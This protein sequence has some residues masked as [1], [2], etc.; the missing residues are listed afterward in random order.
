MVG[1]WHGT[2][3]TCKVKAAFSLH[4]PKVVLD[5]YLGIKELELVNDCQCMHS[6]QITEWQLSIHVATGG[7]DKT[8]MQATALYLQTLTEHW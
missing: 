5:I 4:H 2:P 7:L 8:V 1:F 6:E 3:G